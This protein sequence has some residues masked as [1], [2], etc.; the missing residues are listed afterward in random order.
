MTLT[1]TRIRYF[2]SECEKQYKTEMGAL[3]H[4]SVKEQGYGRI[5]KWVGTERQTQRE[6]DLMTKHCGYFVIC[7]EDKETPCRCKTMSEELKKE[8][9]DCWK[10]IHRKNHDR[11]ALVMPYAKAHRQAKEKARAAK[12]RALGLCQNCN[13]PA[14]GARCDACKLR[15]GRKGKAAP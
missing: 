15:Y 3:R 8:I 10:E 6:G 12:R 4:H 5:E 9:A 13:N 14:T 2:C 1:N 7:T 11:I